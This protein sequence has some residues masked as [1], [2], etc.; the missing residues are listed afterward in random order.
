MP[1]LNDLTPEQA[2][3][4]AE[5][6]H[7]L[8]N[9]LAQYRI[10]NAVTLTNEEQFR[11]GNL[12]SQFLN[13]MNTFIVAGLQNAQNQLTPVL[14]SLATQTKKADKALKSIQNFDKT[15]QIATAAAVLGASVFS[16]DPTA[17]K[18]GIQGLIETIVPP[19]KDAGK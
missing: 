5:T 13:F 2:H 8:A 11:L 18:A 9:A 17:I 7:G 19:A 12:Q 10:T 4:L 6:F 15:L 14:A 16:M 3:D 1:T